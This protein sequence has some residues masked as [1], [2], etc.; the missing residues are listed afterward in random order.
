MSKNE[1]KNHVMH[2]ASQYDDL[3]F[4]AE[5]LLGKLSNFEALKHIAFVIITPDS[6]KRGIESEVIDFILSK[7]RAQVCSARVKH[8]SDRD[9]EELYKYTFR[10]KIIDHKVTFWWLMQRSFQLS[11]CMALLLYCDK[12]EEEYFCETVLNLKG[13]FS[14]QCKP[15]E[16]TVRKHFSSLSRILAIIHSSDD[17]L[18]LMREALIFFNEND[19]A[20][21]IN[22]PLINGI[23]NNVLQLL[24]GNG[25]VPESSA[26][27]VERL[28][29]RIKATIDIKYPALKD[30]SECL[31]KLKNKDNI[32][33]SLI[34]LENS[35]IKLKEIS[36][37][38]ILSMV[39][40]VV[41]SLFGKNSGIP[42]EQIGTILRWGNIY[43]TDWEEI[44]LQN[45]LFFDR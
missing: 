41:L 43:L 5:R 19:F 18:N 33:Q 38:E 7:T 32:E 25:R 39:M 27:T 11:P 24:E 20:D 15:V 44:V 10:Q 8:L 40:K 13:S 42:I 28:I 23:K 21:I 14:V 36:E 4:S 12:H 1:I 22:K 9:I 35:M 2:L 6:I 45:Y 37:H 31:L 29:A 16:D 17:I 30:I 3:S 26:E 34:S